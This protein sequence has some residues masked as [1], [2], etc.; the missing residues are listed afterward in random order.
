M[1]KSF[2]T[3]LTRFGAIFKRN[4]V[5]DETKY[6]ELLK[7]IEGNEGKD[8]DGPL[9]EIH[10]EISESITESY[11]NENIY[12]LFEKGKHYTKFKYDMFFFLISFIKKPM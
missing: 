4:G 8:F 3:L 5:N 12:R 1:R 11:K 10:R 9:R 2:S 7:S 6:H